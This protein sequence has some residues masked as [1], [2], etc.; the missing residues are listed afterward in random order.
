[1]P[2]TNKQQKEEIIA[3]Y[4]AG[5]SAYDLSR[6]FNI[7]N[8]SIYSL[9]SRRGIKRRPIR[10]LSCNESYFE[11]IDC[12]EKAYWL[13]FFFAEGSLDEK[14]YCLSIKL[15][16]EEKEH[17]ER[18]KL[19]IKADH[20]IKQTSDGR[21][22][23]VIKIGSKRLC[24][25]LQKFGLGKGKALNLSWPDIPKIFI[26]DFIR[27]YLDGDGWITKWND[28]KGYQ[29]WSI[30]FASCS[31]CFL[32]MLQ[33]N[34]NHLSGHKGGSLFSRT[35]KNPKWN[36]G[37]QLT[38]G[39]NISVKRV[40]SILYKNATIFLPRKKQIFDSFLLWYES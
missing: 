25:S 33:D 17:L 36:D 23:W 12:E 7:T 38:Y 21:Q 18:F 22:A 11:K 13:G 19:A 40:G 1:M 27:G 35:Y 29:L 10:R 5:E 26:F 34:L 15:G 16:K 20:S 37:H 3:R 6:V 8:Q 39:G 31:K 32:K 24:R 30:G 14:R 4:I 2:Y 28:K 9:L